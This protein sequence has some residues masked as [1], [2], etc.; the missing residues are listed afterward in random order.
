MAKIKTRRTNR[1]E[2]PGIVVLRDAV[3][4]S[5]AHSPGRQGKL[6]LEID[7]DP[8]L[9]HLLRHDPDGFF[10]A[11]VRDETLGFVAAHVRSRQWI[12]SDLWVLPQHHG[13]GAGEALLARALAYGERSGA[14][15]YLALVPST[16]AVQALLLRHELRP[17][18]PVYHLRLARDLVTPAATALSRL[19]PG[20]EMT[21]EL[22]AQRGQ[23]DLDRMDRLTRSVRREVD[24]QYWLKQRDAR[25]AFVQH[26]QR[27]AG[28]GYAVGAHAGPVAASSQDAALAALGWSLKLCAFT[29]PSQPVEIRVPAA[30]SPGVDA[31]LELGAR[32]HSTWMLYSRGVTSAFDRN[33]FGSVSLP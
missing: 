25:V 7:V 29:A 15:E 3:A 11:L 22:L 30:F 4:A 27:S 10:T 33:T 12:L 9:Q 19:L 20:K 8:D 21:S 14:R 24:H 26:K 18:T 5:A 23:A 16:S 13:M 32:L 31:L 1:E 2:L 6:D 17:H 28:F